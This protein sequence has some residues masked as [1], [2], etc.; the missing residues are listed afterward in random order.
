MGYLATGHC[1]GRCHRCHRGRYFYVS[2]RAANKIVRYDLDFANGLSQPHGVTPDLAANYVYFTEFVAGTII[3]FEGAGQTLIVGGLNQ[4]TGLRLDA[5]N[6][7]LY[8]TEWAGQ[9]V[10]RVDLDGNNP[11]DILVSGDGLG[12]MIDLKIYPHPS[13]CTSETTLHYVAFR[14]EIPLLL[15]LALTGLW[16][17][18]TVRK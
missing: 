2:D 11:T 18:K 1:C 3:R 14:S 13:S 16:L 9:K 15:L 17:I 5:T 7:Y 8:F 12:Q 10:R 6:G 4:P